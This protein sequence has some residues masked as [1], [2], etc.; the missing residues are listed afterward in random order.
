MVQNKRSIGNAYEKVAGAYLENLGYEILEYNFYCHR[1]EVDIV[2]RHEGYLVFVEVKYRKTVSAGHPLE[3]LSLRKQRA[4]CHSAFYY[5]HTKGLIHLPV[6][7]DVVGILG[8]EIQVVKNAFD[9][10]C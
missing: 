3:A 1:G 6:R 9:F 2:A 5:M 7:F 4:I 10:V 8:E